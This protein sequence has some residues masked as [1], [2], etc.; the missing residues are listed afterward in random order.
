[1]QHSFKQEGFTFLELKSINN[2]SPYRVRCIETQEETDSAISYDDAASRLIQRH[3]FT[4]SIV[5]QNSKDSNKIHKIFSDLLIGQKKSQCDNLVKTQIAERGL[6][7]GTIISVKEYERFQEFKEYLTDRFVVTVIFGNGLFRGA[8][9][10]KVT[11][12]EN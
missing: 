9:E 8:T 1:M 7:H 11:N 10:V 4:E 6:I 5:D 12:R 2:H 3:R